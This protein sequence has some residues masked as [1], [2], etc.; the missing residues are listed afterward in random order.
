MIDRPD[1]L[2]R[3]EAASA[4]ERETRESWNPTPGQAATQDL[5]YYD[6]NTSEIEFGATMERCQVGAVVRPSWLASRRKGL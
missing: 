1:A 3:A 2:Q 4:R 6:I 5:R